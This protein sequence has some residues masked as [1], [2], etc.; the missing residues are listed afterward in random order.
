M[1]QPHSGYIAMKIEIKNIRKSYGKKAVLRDISFTAESGQ[2]IGILGGNGSG[3]STLFSILAGI[4]LA[5]GGEFTVDG[6]DLLKKP[7]GK[8]LGYIPQTPPLL[9]ELSAADNLSLWYSKRDMKKSL[10]D[11][12]LKRLGID[13][14]LRTTVSKMSGGMK[15]RLSI[16]CSV[17]GD[18]KIILLDEPSAA[19]DLVAKAEIIDYLVSFKNSG[20]TV[21]LATHDANE[22]DFCDVLYIIQ[23]GRLV[24]YDYDGDIARLA[25]ALAGDSA[26]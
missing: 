19:L 22:L 1:W 20:G 6:V 16:G 12:V 3:K 15:K 5:D 14:F 26:K 8:V 25:D 7:D 2:C 23:D 9:E 11:G 18:P 24:K 17:A 10:E 4:N 13:K 21:L